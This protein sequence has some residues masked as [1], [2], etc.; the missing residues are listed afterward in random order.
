M[1][2]NRWVVG[3][4]SLAMGGAF[5][6]E[7]RGL[8]VDPERLSWPALR[9]RVQL[10][11]EPLA[12][13]AATFESAALR[14]RSAAVFGDYYLSRPFFGNTGGV[15]L[16]SGV[17][18]GPRG[19]VFGPGQAT[20]PSPFGFSSASRGPGSTFADASGEGMQTLPYL[21]IG[22]S[23]S[24]LR[25]GWGFSADLGLTAQN[26]GNRR[27]SRTVMSQTLD[28]TLRELRF[29]PVLQLGVSYRF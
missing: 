1:S 9:A 26:G 19:A 23:G 20:A 7:G 4:L 6:A 5:A 3:S 27:L 10:S 14:P 21:G 8:V 25:G 13:T 2:I 16:T 12:S 11:T 15:R 29:T 17:V 24:S 18:A 22:Y 28:D